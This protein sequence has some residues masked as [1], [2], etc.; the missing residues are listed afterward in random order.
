MTPNQRKAIIAAMRAAQK[1]GV[2]PRNNCE[3]QAVMYARL[4][5]LTGGRNVIGKR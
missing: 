3:S 5:K 1:K 2:D 4:A